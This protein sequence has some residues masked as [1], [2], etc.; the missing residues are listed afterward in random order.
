MTKKGHQSLE[1]RGGGTLTKILFCG[2]PYCFLSERSVFSDS[3]RP[4]LQEVC[5]RSVVSSPPQKL[6][7]SGGLQNVSFQT[8]TDNRNRTL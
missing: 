4:R 7:S 6:K 1:G 2:F 8:E 3:L 5:D